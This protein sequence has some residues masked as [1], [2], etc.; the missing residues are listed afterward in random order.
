[1]LKARP[2]VWDIGAAI[3]QRLDLNWW[4]LAHT[5]RANLVDAGH[6]CLLWITRGDNRVPSG[7]WGHGQVL[8]PASL[9]TGDPDDPLWL[10]EVAQNQVRPRIEVE[11][12][13]LGEPITREQILADPRLS[14]M[15][16]LRVPRIGNPSAVTPE[17]WSAIREL[18]P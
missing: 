15:E 17:E 1:M 2:D 16:I 9:G 4:R 5:Y 12:K 6:P 3:E 10:D 18:L 7:I 11:L 8:G 14:A 13:V